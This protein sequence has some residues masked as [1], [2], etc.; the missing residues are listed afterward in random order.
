MVTS[1]PVGKPL[2]EGRSGLRVVIVR[3]DRLEHHF[4]DLSVLPTKV[5]LEPKAPDA[6]KGAAPAKR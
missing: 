2:G 5:E 4:Y 1:G 3:D 6:E